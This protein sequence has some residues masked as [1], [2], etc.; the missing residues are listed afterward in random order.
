MI[1]HIKGNLVSASPSSVIIEAGGLG[2]KVFIPASLFGQLPALESCV[3][4]HTS[5]V[6]RELSQALYGFLSIQ[7]RDLFDALLNVSGIGPKIALSL[8]GHL[9]VFQL[10]Q[11]L[12]QPDINILCKVPGVGKKL[13]ERL[14]IEMRDKI[15][16]FLTH[17]PSEFALPIG[18]DQRSQN[19]QDA[20]S[21]LINLGYNQATAQKAIKKTLPTLPEEFDLAALITQALKN[22]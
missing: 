11:A 2:Y 14:T 15:S 1:A 5:F 16:A 9:S 22:A 21:A 8:I 6:I 4:L 7:E 12:T 10:Q 19:I 17:H 18:F 20:M 13:A 3:L